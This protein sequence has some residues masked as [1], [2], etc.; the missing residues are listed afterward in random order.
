MTADGLA[1]TLRS[2]VEVAR[3]I[4][5]SGILTAERGTPIFPLDPDGYDGEPIAFLAGDPIAH[6]E[7]LREVLGAV[8]AG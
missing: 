2:R 4:E 5:P 7:S 6:D 1:S 3:L 8:E